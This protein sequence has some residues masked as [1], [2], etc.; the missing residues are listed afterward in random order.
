M[1]F[2][3]MKAQGVAHDWRIRNSSIIMTAESSKQ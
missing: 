3:L 1:N 2:L